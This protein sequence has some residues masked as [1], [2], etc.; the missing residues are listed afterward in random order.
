MIG[1]RLLFAIPMLFFATALTFV[2]VSITPGDPAI[3]ILGP[4]ASPAQYAHLRDQLGLSRPLWEQYGDWVRLVLQ[5]DLGQSLFTGQRVTQLLAQRVPVT[6]S[7]VIIGTIVSSIIGIAIGIT[8]ALRGDI[9][10]KM[11]E[12]IALVGLS[13]PGFWAALILVTIFAVDL[14]WLPSTGYVYVK[15]S[16]WQW[17][18]SLILPVAA[19]SIAPI[20]TIAKQTRDSFTDTL[21]RDFIRVMQANGFSRNSILFRHALRNAAIP[22][23][24][25]LGISFTHLLSG[26]VVIEH[27]FALPGLGTATVQGVTQ[28]DLPI[29]Q[30]VVFYLTLT[31]L[32][33]NLLID[34]AYGWLNPKVRTS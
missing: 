28:H 27:I 8:A 15:Q 25:V 32:A 29:I 5:G 6:L 34:L 17:A 18:V 1:R 31:V 19:I 22:I 26:T 30:G 20:A 24:T 3:T 23:L 7:V 11:L 14:G 16:P 2:L 4:D 13:I 21:N 10:G 12:N 33:V 9:F